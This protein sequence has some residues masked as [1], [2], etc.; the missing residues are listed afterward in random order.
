MIFSHCSFALPSD[1]LINEHRTE[2]LVI[3]RE[4]VI[5]EV[6]AEDGCQCVADGIAEGNSNGSSGGVRDP[7]ACQRLARHLK[8]K[9][10]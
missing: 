3:W 2:L 7:V 1:V 4:A 10:P 6:N 8:G 5:D 9:H